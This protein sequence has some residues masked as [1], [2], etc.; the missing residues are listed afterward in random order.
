M[1]QKHS[2]PITII[3]KVNQYLHEKQQSP[4]ML[5]HF[6]RRLCPEPIQFEGWWHSIY[7]RKPIGQIITRKEKENTILNVFDVAYTE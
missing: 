3:L 1:I 2:N 5:H 6:Q 4:G 7:G